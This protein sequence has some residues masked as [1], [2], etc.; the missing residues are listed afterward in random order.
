MSYLH[1]RP[2]SVVDSIRAIARARGAV[3]VHR[4]ELEGHDPQDH[5][6]FLGTMERVLEFVDEHF[7]GPATWLTAHGLAISH[8]SGSGWHP[9]RSLRP[10]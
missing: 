2:D 6:P 9:Q 7:G 8:N 4:A 3:L 5:A 1:R 10:D